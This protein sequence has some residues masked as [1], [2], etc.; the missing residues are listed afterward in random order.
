MLKRDYDE[1]RYLESILEKAP[2]EVSYEVLTE[3]KYKGN[4]Y[5]IHGISIGAKGPTIPVFAM[6]GGVHG[7]EKVGTH[8]VLAYLNYIFEQLRWNE[9]LKETFKRI[10]LECIPMVNPVGIRH[11]RRSNGN[12]VD[13]MRNSPFVADTKTTFM[14]GGHRISPKLPWYQGQENR[15]EIESQVLCDFVKERVL[16]STHAITI[17][18]HSGFGLQDRLW[19]PYAGS[20]KVFDGQDE[21]DNLSKMLDKNLPHHIYIFEPQHD[22]Y[23]MSGD[24]WDYLYDF[25]RKEVPNCHF[26]PLTLEMGSWAWLKKNPLQLFSVHGLYN[27]M[28]DHRFSRI[29]RR[30]FLMIDFF[31]KATKHHSA[32]SQVKQDD[33]YLKQLD[34]S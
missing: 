19:Y 20:K 27:P 34:N 12:G 29:M 2:P 26:I 8:V 33:S 14:V 21:I 11:H 1:F 25:Q 17:D 7:L 5:P 16:T 22:H 31:F 30:H 13:L 15:M 6:F 3:I 18:F 28:R 24:I 4:E 23:M 9:D 32:W 10:R